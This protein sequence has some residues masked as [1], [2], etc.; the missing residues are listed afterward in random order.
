MSLESALDARLAQ[1]DAESAALESELEAFRDTV[2]AWKCACSGRHPSYAAAHACAYCKAVECDLRVLTEQYD[3]APNFDARRLFAAPAVCD[4]CQT[5]LPVYVGDD[6]VIDAPEGFD[7][8]CDDCRKLFIREWC[9]ECSNELPWGHSKQPALIPAE[10][11]SVD[12]VD[13]C[14]ECIKLSPFCASEDC[15]NSNRISTP[16]DEA[17]RGE[18]CDECTAKREAEMREYAWMADAV[19]RAREDRELYICES[20]DKHSSTLDDDLICT[21]CRAGRAVA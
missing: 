12:T 14:P 1:D 16:R 10:H 4:C 21:P 2:D 7:F 19:K 18:E 8:R 9:T 6:V 5:Q 3:H 15:E 13:V 20:C 11:R 17:C